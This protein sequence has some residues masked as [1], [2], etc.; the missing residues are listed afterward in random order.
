M[1]APSSQVKSAMVDTMGAIY[2]GHFRLALQTLH[3]PAKAFQ[4]VENA[5]SPISAK[6]V[7]WVAY[8]VT[9]CDLRVE[10]FC[11]FTQI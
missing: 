5:R 7:R 1:N 10:Q 11:S 4:I 9:Y 2:L 3:S 6:S 8:A